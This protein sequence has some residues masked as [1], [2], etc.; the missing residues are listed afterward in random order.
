MPEKENA[1]GDAVNTL[2][3]QS[4]KRQKEALGKHVAA[5]VG[6]F[7][8]PSADPGILGFKDDALLRET[9]R[10]R[11][12]SSSTGK[13]IEIKDDPATPGLALSS[14]NA[15]LVANHLGDKDF[16][17]EIMQRRLD[18]SEKVEGAMEPS[19]TGLPDAPVLMSRERTAEAA[20]A[21]NV[22]MAQEPG[23]PPSTLND[24]SNDEK[25]ILIENGILKSYMIDKINGRRM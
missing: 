17:G 7:K 23:P 15:S 6:S 13:T 18:T 21:K 5:F 3:D 24:S 22:A 14:V 9:A 1:R 19:P 8:T 4:S 16:I 12:G 2:A 10:Y 25:T 20:S 11:T